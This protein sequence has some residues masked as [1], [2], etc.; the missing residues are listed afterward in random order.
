MIGE[1][2]LKQRATLKGDGQLFQQLLF[3]VHGRHGSLQWGT[4]SFYP[5]LGAKDAVTGNHI[6]VCDGGVIWE[7]D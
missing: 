3:V 7:W 4:N 5:W 1:T 2:L 6:E